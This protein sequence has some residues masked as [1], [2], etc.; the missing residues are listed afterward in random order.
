MFYDDIS[1]SLQY[2]RLSAV[3]LITFNENLDRQEIASCQDKKSLTAL[4]KL[5]SFPS[6]STSSSSVRCNATTPRRF[7]SFKYCSKKVF[8]VCVDCSDPCSS[9]VEKCSSKAIAPC[10][11]SAVDS[12][13]I[14]DNV[15]KLLIFEYSASNVESVPAIKTP[16]TISPSTNSL[17]VSLGVSSSVNA[18]ASCGLFPFGYVLTSVSGISSTGKTVVPTN[19]IA[20]F[21]FTG[22]LGAS[23]YTMYCSTA[24]TDGQS[25]SLAATLQTRTNIRTKCCRSVTISLSSNQMKTGTQM[26]NTFV[27]SLTALHIHMPIL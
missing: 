5:I 1:I 7:F 12:C 25:L 10:A 8:S 24:T 23:N 17:S 4:M 11:V 27:V 18:I 14:T 3:E 20:S 21:A 6:S 16:F 26:A 9:A 15:A 19:N 13:S 22:L 2:Q